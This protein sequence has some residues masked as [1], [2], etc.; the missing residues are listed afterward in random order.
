MPP[1]LRV[2]VVTYAGPVK[3]TSVLAGR[4]STPGDDLEVAGGLERW[5][6]RREG[7]RRPGADS[8][9]RGANLPGCLRELHAGTPAEISTSEGTTPQQS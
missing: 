1:L 5:S 4:L 2:M 9:L 3:S 7:A 8:D 6:G